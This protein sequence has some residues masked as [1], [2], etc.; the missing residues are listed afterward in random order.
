MAFYAPP[1]GITAAD[2][3]DYLAAQIAAAYTGAETLILQALKRRADRAL[4]EMPDLHARL[5]AVR[6]LRAEAQRALSGLDPSLAEQIIKAATEAGIADA[7]AQ[8]ELIPRLPA[9]SPFTQT[10]AMAVAQTMFDLQSTFEALHLRILRWDVDEYQRLIAGQVPNVLLGAQGKLEAQKDAVQKWLAQGIPGFVDKAGRPWKVGSYVE[11]ATR[12][13]VARAYTDAGVWRMQQ[14]GL[15]LVTVVVGRSACPKCAPWIGK[16]LSTDGQT[17]TVEV[18]HATENRTVEVTIAATLE[19]A[20]AE[21]LFHPNCRCTTA[22]YLPG[23]PIAEAADHYD[24]VQEAARDKQRALERDIRQSKRDLLL[25]DDANKQAELK[26]DIR[27]TQAELRQ[28]V[29]ANDLP[30]K[31]WREQVRF[32]D[33]K[34]Q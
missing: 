28:H 21:G 2:L 31:P 10:S 20:R 1:P 4:T 25:T 19:Q 6:Y 34:P 11:M 33:G 29:E 24:P 30:R 26:R 22:A 3:I 17:G 16:V 18:E 14:A 32:A 23:L 12:T 8:I 5:E 7:V 13:A 27:A 15:N 9:A